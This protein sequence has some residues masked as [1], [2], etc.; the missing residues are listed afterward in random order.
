[1]R[2]SVVLAWIASS[3]LFVA[4]ACTKQNDTGSGGRGGSASGGVVSGGATGKGGTSGTDG[5]SAKGGS[6]GSGGAAGS[7]VIGGSG[8]KGGAAGSGGAGGSA[9]TGG[10]KGGAGGAAS[11]GSAGKSAGG[12]GGAA[13][14]GGSSGAGGSTAAGGTGGSTA[15]ACTSP[16]QG[17]VTISAPSGLFK[18]TLA[19]TLSTSISGAE[20]R[21]TTDGK[22]PTSSSTLYAGE[23]KLTGT[24]R[25]RA[26]AFV[27]GSAS[28]KSSGAVYVATTI[29]A[30]HDLPVIVLDSYGSGKLPTAEAQR[31]FVDVAYLAMEPASS[32]TVKLSDKPA[33]ATFAAFHVRGN[34]SAMFDKVPYRLE[35]RNEAG[36]DRDCP[37]LGMPAES[38][39]ALVGPHSDKTLIHNNFIYELGHDMGM[40]TPRVKLAE[41]YVNVDKDPLNDADYQGVYQIIETIKNQKN[42]LNLKQLN[43]TKTTDADISGGY[44]FSFEWMITAEHPITCPS[45]TANPWSYMELVDPVPFAT[46]QMDYLTKHL[47]SFHTALH[48]SNIAD[49]S[50]GYPNYIEPKTWVDQIIVNELGRNMDAYARSQYFYKDRNAKINAG[51][52]WDFDLIAGS[53]LN[54]TAM[55]NTAAEGWQYE[56]NASRLGGATSTSTGTGGSMGFPGGGFPGGGFPG[57]NSSGTADWFPILLK[58]PTFKAQLI[59][60]WKELRGNLLSDNAIAS[61]IDG[62][63]A[64]LSAAADR[65]FAKWKILSQAQVAPFDTPTAS[66]WAAQIT[67]MKDWL[68]KRAAWLDS[69]WK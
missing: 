65:N 12:A 8:G 19:V 63:T 34:S 39:W 59:A 29:D 1:M 67:Y 22:A 58:D 18:G 3:S 20:I 43:E 66:T 51:P 14:V 56:G 30:T 11:G 33:V 52:L 60:R 9:A 37:V 31:Q 15:D 64:G 44:I 47:V 54:T 50:T 48:G 55:A 57:G 32:S 24:T 10:A 13:S 42:R 2:S 61:R 7:G 16:A 40:A 17:D 35:L 41:V 49:A 5:T 38:D 69:Q 46:Q 25:L 23:I 26:Q 68:K 27:Q 6:S 36:E 21:Y 4:A 62:L 53:G 28:G 45:G